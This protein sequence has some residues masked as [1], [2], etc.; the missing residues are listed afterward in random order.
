MS[1]FPDDTIR[2]A[3]ANEEQKLK[4]LAEISEWLGMFAEQ[5]EIAFGTH[6]EIRPESVSLLNS[7]YWENIEANVR[8]RMAPHEG[9][10]ER[11][12]DRHKIASAMELCICAVLPLD[13]ATAEERISLN[14]ELAFYVGLSII[15]NWNPD[16]IT[17]LSVSD[18]FNRE[19][20]A[21]LREVNATRDFQI[22]SNAATWYLFE[23][24][25]LLKSSIKS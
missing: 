13:A 19:H 18:S 25:C 2:G 21:W 12:I 7:T 10:D 20:L 6:I 11:V 1:I 4:R 14:A 9:S 3:F 15:G 24:Y 16:K 17:T 8:P 22:F 23:Q 5:Y